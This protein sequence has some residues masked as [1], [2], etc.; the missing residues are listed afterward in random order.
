MAGSERVLSTAEGAVHRS[1]ASKSRRLLEN[2][3][4]ADLDEDGA[5]RPYS[6][7][8]AGREQRADDFNGAPTSD[9]PAAVATKQWTPWGK[10]TIPRLLSEALMVPSI[11][12]P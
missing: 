6:R 4:G 2:G 9:R 11:A 1:S 5:A 12:G 3:S 10:P 8:R 7:C